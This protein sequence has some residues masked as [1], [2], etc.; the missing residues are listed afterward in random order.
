MSLEQ[1]ATEYIVSIGTATLKIKKMPSL[2]RFLLRKEGVY[3]SG[4]DLKVGYELVFDESLAANKWYGILIESGGTVGIS[5]YVQSNGDTLGWYIRNGSEFLKTLHDSDALFDTPEKVIRAAKLAYDKLTE[6]NT[7]QDFIYP[8]YDNSLQVLEEDLDEQGSID[9]FYYIAYMDNDKSSV[10]VVDYCSGSKYKSND[11]KLVINECFTHPKNAI[12]YAK[13]F[14][15][16]NQLKYE[17]F[18][19][20]YHSSYAGG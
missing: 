7:A 1:F 16:L 3:Y 13:S 11:L 4:R 5:P 2:N 15:K 20:K 8:E 14:A 10:G 18:D 9:A 19:S 17:P 12:D 6:S